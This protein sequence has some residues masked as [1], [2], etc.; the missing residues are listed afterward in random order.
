MNLETSWRGNISHPGWSD[1]GEVLPELRDDRY[2]IL[3]RSPTEFMQAT[4]EQVEYSD[5]THHFR[6]ETAG[7]DPNLVLGLFTSY[8][9]DDDRWRSMV[10][11]TDMTDEV[12]PT[13]RVKPGL[14]VAVAV[15]VI[16]IGAIAAAVILR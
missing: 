14:L 3:S 5:G 10:E 15:V 13:V 9:S 11:W 8:A 12:H 16:I 4:P 2:I 1:L 6:Y 7:A